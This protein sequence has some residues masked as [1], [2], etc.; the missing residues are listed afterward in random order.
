MHICTAAS[1]IIHYSKIQGSYRPL[2][3]PYI[4]ALNWKAHIRRQQNP[5]VKHLLSPYASRED[6][7]SLHQ[8]FHSQQD[9]C[10]IFFPDGEKIRQL[11]SGY[12][13]SLWEPQSYQLLIFLQPKVPDTA[14]QSPSPRN[15][16]SV[17]SVQVLSLLYPFTVVSQKNKRHSCY[18]LPYV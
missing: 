2:A 9:D 14:N 16:N 8:H 7:P 17:K 12:A 18:I 4:Q 13:A 1:D 11:S 15:T 3:L 6:N 10:I 5:S